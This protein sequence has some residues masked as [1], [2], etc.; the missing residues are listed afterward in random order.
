MVPIAFRS[1]GSG[2]D[3]LLIAGQDGSLSW[4]DSALLRTCRRHYRVTV[5]DLPGVGYSGAATAPSFS[6]GWLADMT[7]GFALAAGLFS[8][9]RARLGTRRRYCVCSL[10]ERHP[11]L[12]SSLVLVDTSAGGAGAP[13]PSRS[14]ARLMALPGA[15]PGGPGE[16][17]LSENQRRVARAR[18][19][20]EQ[21]LGHTRLADRR[22]HHRGGHTP[23]AIWRASPLTRELS[24]VTI[25][26]LVV[27][28]NDDLVFPPGT[29]PLL[30]GELRHAVLLTLVIRAMERFCK[31]S[32]LS[33]WPSRDSPA[34]LRA[35]LC[36]ADGAGPPTCPLVRP[37]CVAG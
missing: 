27:S 12:A 33:S 24:R 31:T 5:F 10:A 3:L 30:E 7:A 9:G 4:W 29:C 28:G 34:E 8:P 25:P 35:G 14:V 23:A 16:A 6:L 37:A 17:S 19:M 22:R 36:P 18:P 13:Q 26:V 15:T 20:G 21:P 11:G 1:L 32:R 2:P